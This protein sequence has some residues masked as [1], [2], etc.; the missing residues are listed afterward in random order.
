[1]GDA[2]RQMRARVD[3]LFEDSGH[4]TCEQHRGHELKPAR[5]ERK[6]R[7]RAHAEGDPR[8]APESEVERR[9]E[10]WQRCRGQRAPKETTGLHCEGKCEE[11]A[12]HRK[13]P[14]CIPVAERLLEP[15]RS[16]VIDH[17]EPLREEPRGKGVR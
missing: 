1:M 10:D 4:D 6:H 3:I 5:L 13:H 12:H 15:V 7:Q 14:D 2:T 9:Q 11:R 17:P 16:E 8:T